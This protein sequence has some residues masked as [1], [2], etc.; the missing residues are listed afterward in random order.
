MSSTAIVRYPKDTVLFLQGEMGESAFIIEKGRVLIYLT[1]DKEDFPLSVLGE[2]EIFGEMA[3][4]DNQVR[5]ASA[6]ALDDCEL[7]PVTKDMLMERV[8]VADTVVRLLLR[9]LLKRLRSQND[10]IAR[11]PKKEFISTQIVQ[12]EDIEAV[13]KIKLESRLKDAFNNR[14]FVMYYQPIVDFSHDEIIGAEA[15]IRWLPQTGEQIS[16]AVF[17]DVIESSSF[18]IPFGRWILQECFKDLKGIQEKTGNKSFSLS[19]N[20]SGKQFS[21]PNFIEDVEK[22]RTAKNLK[23]TTIKL[24]MTERVMMDGTLAL[25]TL[26]RFHDLGYGLSIDDFG[27]GFSSLQ[28]LFRMPLDNIKI[29]RSFVRDMLA[30]DKALAIV[31]SL[32][33][34]AQSLRMRVIAEGIERKEEKSLLKALGVE[35]GQGFLFSKA[36][37]L[38]DFMQLLVIRK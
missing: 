27:T 13:K 12:Q 33:Y 29:D 6:K 24:E 8:Q 19:I 21:Q 1:K 25:D 30:D 4:L 16:P 26:K 5:S 14:E 18:M 3:I 15:L 35:Q 37:S 38:H 34:L 28:Y 32:I 2:G 10:L 7:I 11:E 22:M 17:M 20:I 31:K 9:V 36:V 23:A